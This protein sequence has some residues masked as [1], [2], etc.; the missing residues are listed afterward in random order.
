MSRLVSDR[1]L[2]LLHSMAKYILS[3]LSPQ[4]CASLN[5]LINMSILSVFC[6]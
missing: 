6:L 2:I 5:L 3:S 4:V 1:L